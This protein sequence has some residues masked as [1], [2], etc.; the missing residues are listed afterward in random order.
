MLVTR[1]HKSENIRK[2]QSRRT[3]LEVVAPGTH[4]PLSNENWLQPW[5]FLPVE[6]EK[7][8]KEI[9]DFEVKDNDVYVVTF[10]KCGTTWIQE[11]TWLL[12]N[13]LDFD[14]ANSVDL[15]DRSNFME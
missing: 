10:P 9:Y 12:M 11:A 1:S 3:C 8:L 14:T 4:I 2:R 15:S 7:L 6:D 13:G 5:C